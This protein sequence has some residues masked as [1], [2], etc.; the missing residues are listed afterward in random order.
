[1]KHL[2]LYMGS[3]DDAV[4]QL[5][6][7]WTSNRPDVTLDCESIHDNPAAAVRMGITKLPALVMEDELVAQ[8]APENWVTRLLDRLVLQSGFDR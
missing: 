8:G 2:K 3:T 6:E 5:L 4:R 1:M 7:E